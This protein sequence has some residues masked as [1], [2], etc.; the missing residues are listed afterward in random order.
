[1]AWTREMNFLTILEA[2]GLRSWFWQDRLFWGLCVWLVDGLASS[3]CVFTG[4]S[5]CACLC[6][7]F[8]FFFFLQG[9]QS[10]WISAHPNVFNWLL[11]IALRVHISK[12]SHILRNWDLEL[13]PIHFERDTVDTINSVL[14]MILAQ[15]WETNQCSVPSWC[16]VLKPGIGVGK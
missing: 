9:H 15:G 3:P 2:G 7:D 8:F 14:V 10:Y 1:M 11:L 13:Q 6:A 5:L 4:P 12:Y 16:P